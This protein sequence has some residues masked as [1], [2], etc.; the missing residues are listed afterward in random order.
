MSNDPWRAVREAVDAFIEYNKHHLTADAGLKR[1]RETLANLFKDQLAT[2]KLS[3]WLADHIYSLLKDEPTAANGRKP[4]AF[5]LRDSYVAEAVNLAMKAGL[6]ATKNEATEDAA[7]ACS[8]V[9]EGLAGVG[10][11]MTEGAVQK[12]WVKQ[13]PRIGLRDP[14]KVRN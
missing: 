12:I 2:G 14:P 6:K 4:Y 7:S 3:P 10:V 11:N 9:A 5:W 1:N 8:I 13:G